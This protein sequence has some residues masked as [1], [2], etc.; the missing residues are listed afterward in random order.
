MEHGC[1]DGHA[2]GTLQP[3]LGWVECQQLAYQ[4]ATAVPQQEKRSVIMQVSYCSQRIAA[5]FRVTATPSRCSSG[6]AC[7][8]ASRRGLARLDESFNPTPTAAEISVGS[9][10]KAMYQFGD[11]AASRCPE[12]QDAKKET[13]TWKV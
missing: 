8:S 2:D 5:R 3:H 9:T 10:Y 13:P 1:V 6:L 12:A 4:Q 7:S 11:V